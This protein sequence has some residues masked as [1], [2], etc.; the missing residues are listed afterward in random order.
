MNKL[1]LIGRIGKDAE[2]RYSQDGKPVCSFSVAVDDGYS[3]K[4]STIWVRC[5]LWGERAEKLAPHLTKGKPVYVEG[6]LSHDDNGGPRTWTDKATNETRTSFEC[7]VTSVE[8]TPSTPKSE[9]GEE[10]F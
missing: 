3:D 2:L 9:S 8:F 5:S 4:K 1:S 10:P 6:N 7:R